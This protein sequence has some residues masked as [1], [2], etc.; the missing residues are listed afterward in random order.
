[1]EIVFLLRD[2]ERPVPIPSPSKNKIK[3]HLFLNTEY[4][5]ISIATIY[6]IDSSKQKNIFSKTEADKVNLKSFSLPVEKKIHLLN[7]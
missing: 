5:A 4:S 7:K 1:M 2:S 3:I 6:I